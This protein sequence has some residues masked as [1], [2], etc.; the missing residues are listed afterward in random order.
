[1]KWSLQELHMGNQ[2]AS[3]KGMRFMRRFIRIFSIMWRLLYCTTYWIIHGVHPYSYWY[4]GELILR[5]I[6]IR[7]RDFKKNMKYTMGYSPILIDEVLGVNGVLDENAYPILDAAIIQII[8]RMDY[9][10]S[11]INEDIEIEDWQNYNKYNEEFYKLLEK[12][13]HMF[14]D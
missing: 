12:Y 3:Y 14:Y 5:N 10:I 9:L 13:S 6:Q 4:A 7:I 1:M 2:I 11:V 8:D